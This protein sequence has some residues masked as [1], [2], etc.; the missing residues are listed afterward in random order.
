[1]YIKHGHVKHRKAITEKLPFQ[2]HS[3]WDRK[4]ES[5]TL[6]LQKESKILIA[7]LAHPALTQ[8]AVTSLPDVLGPVGA[9]AS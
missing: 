9:R 3:Y 1:M 8:M 5:R 6:Q 2:M 7:L 4:H